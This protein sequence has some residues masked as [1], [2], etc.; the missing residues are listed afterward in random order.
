MITLGDVL[1]RQVPESRKYK[2][3][4][5]IDGFNLY[6]GIRREAINC[7]TRENPDPICYRLLWL[8]LVALGKNMLSPMQTLVATKYFAAPII[9]SPDKQDRQNKYFDALR[10]R[11]NLE[12]I[13][14][15]FEPDRKDCDKCG[16][17]GFHPQEKKTDVNIAT[18]LIID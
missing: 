10:T 4:T 17:P 15:R 14:G 16:H 5:Y 6:F 2:V 9:D 18:N 1:S 7:G 3:I 8:D 13:L 11:E 12:I